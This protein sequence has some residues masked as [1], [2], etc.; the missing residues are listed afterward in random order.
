[1]IV[2]KIK[3]KTLL[4]EIDLFLQHI[5]PEEYKISFFQESPSFDLM[6]KS[7]IEAG[8]LASNFSIEFNAPNSAQLIDLICKEMVTNM[9]LASDEYNIH[10]TLNGEFLV[11]ITFNSITQEDSENELVDILERIKKQKVFSFALK[12]ENFTRNLIHDFLVKNLISLA[13]YTTWECVLACGATRIK[14]NSRHRRIEQENGDILTVISGIELT[15][16]NV[17]REKDVH[18]YLNGLFD[19]LNAKKTYTV[20]IRN[21]KELNQ[22][23][24]PDSDLFKMQ[25]SLKQ[26]NKLHDIEPLLTKNYNVMWIYK[27]WHEK[28]PFNSLQ[29]KCTEGDNLEVF[30]SFEEEE[31][32]DS[33]QEKL[34]MDVEWEMVYE[35]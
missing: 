18:L 10:Y 27:N 17:K 3:S 1:M 32:R 14:P 33:F 21:L 31:N 12:D 35:E 16:P 9:T 13:P 15:L 28:L 24:L 8:G 22:L 34:Q 7:V 20:Y 26:T 23:C 2:Y 30:M 11:D 25:C 5:N 19:A 6:K 4:S 29:L